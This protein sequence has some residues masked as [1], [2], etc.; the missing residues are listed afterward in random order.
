MKGD[1]T[2]VVKPGMNQNTILC[3][4]QWLNELGTGGLMGPVMVFRN[5]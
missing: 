2:A 5:K 4:R 1:V 3:E